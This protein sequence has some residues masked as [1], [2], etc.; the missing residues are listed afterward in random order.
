MIETPTGMMTDDVF[1]KVLVSKVGSERILFDQFPRP[2]RDDWSVGNSLLICDA[3]LCSRRI[4]ARL[5]GWDLMISP[6]DGASCQ[7][8]GNILRCSSN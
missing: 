1:N 6:R 2:I 4:G 5:D 8:A 7:L 3:R